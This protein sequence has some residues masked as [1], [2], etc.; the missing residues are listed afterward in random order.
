[1]PDGTR[2]LTA[3]GGAT[4][5]LWDASTGKALTRFVG[6]S[7]DLKTLNHAAF[8]PDGKRVL[9]VVQPL[10]KWP[11]DAN[12]DQTSTP[13][14]FDAGTGRELVRFEGHKQEVTS[15]T[16]SPDGTR[17][18]TSSHD[19][20]ARIW[21]AERGRELVRLDGHREPIR[22]ATFSPDGARLVTVSDD[23]TARLWQA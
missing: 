22:A 5:Q 2:I 8:S 17:V 3:A 13:R 11:P 10:P 6:D 20:T 4:A 7:F 16:F 23:D 1:S 9:T 21:D 12:P 19:R 14:L 18:L 15:L